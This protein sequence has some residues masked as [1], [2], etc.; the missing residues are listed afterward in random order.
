MGVRCTSTRVSVARSFADVKCRNVQV[1]ISST[2]RLS[3]L[4]G[5]QT[6]LG[7]YLQES[8]TTTLFIGGVNRYVSST[9]DIAF[10]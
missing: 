6:P 3:G 8:E 7:L 5:A 4:W 10:R 9:A 2:D 1:D